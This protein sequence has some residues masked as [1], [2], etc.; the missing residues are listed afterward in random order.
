MDFNNLPCKDHSK[1]LR[2]M[3]AVLNGLVAGQI[4]L[5]GRLELMQEKLEA[6]V[7]AITDRQDV[8]NGR[9]N[10]V[11]PVVQ[12]LEVD[13]AAHDSFVPGFS[14]DMAKH[15]HEVARK[16]SHIWDEIH[17]LQATE[18]AVAKKLDFGKGYIGGVTKMGQV[19]WLLAGAVLLGCGWAIGLWIAHA[20][21]AKPG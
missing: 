8:T 4:R 13:V 9:L 20:Q 5:E 10:R 2:Q 14:K 11:E 19:L 21:S 17:A 1:T 15:E 16:I 12:R 18:R 3:T 7:S 6:G